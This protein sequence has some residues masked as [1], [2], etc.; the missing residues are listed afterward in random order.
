MHKEQVCVCVCK[1]EA[2]SDFGVQS[3]TEASLDM[4]KSF[5]AWVF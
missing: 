4:F 3:C 1:C 2:Y 5:T